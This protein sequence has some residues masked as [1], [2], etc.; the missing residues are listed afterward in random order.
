MHKIKTFLSDLKLNLTTG[1]VS[2]ITHRITGIAF[3]VF[4]FLH[5]FTL[6]SVFRGPEAFENALLLYD[7]PFGYS[8]EF[9]LMFAVSIHLINGVR[10]TIIDFLNLSFVHKRYFWISFI[11]F[12]IIVILSIAVFFPVF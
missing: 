4:L 3:L 11:V 10:I 5:V 12:L 9:A 6:S 2:H 8:L 7:N 1:T